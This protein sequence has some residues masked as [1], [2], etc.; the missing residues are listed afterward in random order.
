[1]AR[2]SEH[3]REELE[4]LLLQQ[5]RFIV[6][7]HGFEGLT[8]RKLADAIGYTPGTIYNVF[9]S[10][11]ELYL[12]INAETLDALQCILN[13][14]ECRDP[15]CSPVDNMKFMA[16]QYKNFCGSHRPYWLMLFEHRLSTGKDVPPWF[17]EKI[18]KL[19]EP[20][21]SLLDKFYDAGEVR[22]RRMAARILW[23]SVHGIC[24]LEQSGKFKLV[25]NDTT[26]DHMMDYLI[27]CF[28][29]GIQIQK[30]GA[31]L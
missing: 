10:M 9:H 2:R 30:R 29:S 15:A 21:E 7:A 22:R 19:F 31:H 18:E 24:F 23:S 11:D 8:A 25:N 27:D 13:A 26:I 14:P 12:R 4:N 5:A 20:L 3:S 28:V 1:M 6:G 17:A 16:A